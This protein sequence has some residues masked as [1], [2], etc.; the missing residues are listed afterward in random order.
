MLHWNPASQNIKNNLKNALIS[1]CKKKALIE[2][3]VPFKLSVRMR[4]KWLSKSQVASRKNPTSLLIVK[5]WSAIEHLCEP[6]NA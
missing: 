1:W 6:L 4:K 3:H 2:I 5:P